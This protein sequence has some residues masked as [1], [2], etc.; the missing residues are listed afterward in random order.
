MRCPQPYEEYEY[1]EK[2][3][4]RDFA[5]RDFLDTPLDGAV[6]YGSVF[7]NETPEAEIFGSADGTVFIR[8]NMDNVAI[9][10]GATLID[11]TQKRFM[12]QNDGNDWLLGED[13]LPEKPV[14]FKYYEKRGLPVP[15]RSWI[16][17]EKIEKGKDPVDLKALA[18]EA[19]AEMIATEELSAVTIRK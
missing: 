14:D 9:P 4:F 11:C 7:S 13:G 10:K 6:I 19:K 8:C 5:N 2:L 12:V 16:P 18:V 1:D 15:D 17:S 3:S